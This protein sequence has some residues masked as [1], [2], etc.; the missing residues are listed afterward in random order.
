[1]K[2]VS[3]FKLGLRSTRILIGVDKHTFS[4]V[5]DEFKENKHVLSK[6][7]ID[8]SLK[9]AQLKDQSDQ[10][11]KEIEIF[12]LE[13]KLLR[14]MISVKDALIHS[15]DALLDKE[16]VIRSFLEA[17]LLS[18][19]HKLHCRGV[20]ERFEHITTSA[21]V[22]PKLTRS[23][24]WVKILKN[25][26][27]LQKSLSE[28]KGFPSSVPPCDV[29]TVIT[30]LVREFYQRLSNDIHKDPSGQTMCIINKNFCSDWEM[31]FMVEICN[32]IPVR[33]K[34]ENADQ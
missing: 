8:D 31:R 27:E 2:A 23:A 20:I 6:P 14:E 19:K 5:N 13:S 11:A 32:S 3:T 15:K 9:M 7:N 33:H 29:P 22:G 34:V 24:T 16:M 17:E 26:Y 30:K 4:A 18:I 25:D 12:K 28:L 10:S 21:F 1:M